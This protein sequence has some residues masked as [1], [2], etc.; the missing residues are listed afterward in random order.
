MVVNRN[1]V[2]E[3][4]VAPLAHENIQWFRGNGCISANFWTQFEPNTSPYT[5]HAVQRSDDGRWF[6]SAL[7]SAF[8]CTQQSAPFSQKREVKF[9]L[10]SKL[11]VRGRDTYLKKKCYRIVE[12]K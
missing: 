3:P 12:V 9:L 1:P 5:Q 4:H 2:M 8:C 6:A 7:G 11:A 10:A